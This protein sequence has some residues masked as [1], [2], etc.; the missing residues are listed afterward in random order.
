MHA[1]TTRFRG[2]VD[3]AIAAGVALLAF[4]VASGSLAGYVAV[5][6]V[7][8][9]LQPCT[10]KPGWVPDPAQ[11]QALPQWQ[12][13][14]NGEIA[15]FPCDAIRGLPLV[16]VGSSW[17]QSEYFHRALGA[18]YRI[19]GPTATA[20]ASFQAALFALTS[21]VLFG[22]F[23]LGMGRTLALVCTT[24]LIFSRWQLELLK[25][26]IEYAKAPGILATIWLCGLMIR[27]DLEGR[28]IRLTAFLAGLAAGVGSGFKP[29]VLA[30]IP[31]AWLTAAIFI[32]GTSRRVWATACVVAGVVAGG[33]P[34]LY[35]ALFND[36]GSLLAVQFLG[37]Q[38][39]AAEAMFANASLYDY[40][41]RF[42]D[43]HITTLL[44]VYGRQMSG[45]TVPFYLFSREMQLASTQLLREL[46]TTFPGDLVLRIIA[47]IVRLL[48][49]GGLGLL[50][51]ALG[52][53]ALWSYRLRAGW[54][55]AFV[56]VYLAS[57]VSLVFQR[58]H[59]FHLEFM[60]WWLTG[61]LAHAIWT[62]A[63][64]KEP[65]LLEGLWRRAGV[66]AASLIVLVVAAAVLLVLAR[67][68]QHRTVSRGIE[69]RLSAPAEVREIAG[70]AEGGRT[71]FRI[72]GV[73]ADSAHTPPAD[74]MSGDYL[75]V[76]L[77]CGTGPA[78]S[79]STR[80]LGGG[81]SWDREQS[82]PCS[83]G[84]SVLM[85]PV[86]QY[87][88]LYRFDGLSLASE[89]AAKVRSVAVVRDAPVGAWLHLTLPSDW[90]RHALYKTL[91]MPPVIP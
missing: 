35:R 58:R 25:F 38:D 81:S 51:A 61:F 7:E 72:E 55:A 43:A 73:S 36:A 4:A 44:N 87:G 17:Q 16:E 50:A 90:R 20:F 2:A 42:D 26:P 80:Y 8:A 68:V 34:V 10:G 41:L 33:A 5:P 45:D 3:P 78:V 9:F 56:A 70:H 77:A 21:A 85:L 24:V 23:R 37:G 11:V 52:M 54:F 86:Y 63:R 66:A 31:L 65:Q 83:T 74:S 57:Y 75:S 62:A 28:P 60:G 30:A 15:A 48:Q 69:A 84:E 59:F 67:A 91:R 1:L 18:W 89:D 49:F 22:L 64:R 40:G 46:W 76:R 39:S 13:L 27:R 79:L 82:V 29:D 19:T 32:R 88:S 71:L 53:V 12:A 47:A 14:L 6:W